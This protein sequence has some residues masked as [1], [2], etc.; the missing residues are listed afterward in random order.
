MKRHWRIGL[1]AI[2]IF[3]SGALVGASVSVAVMKR[4]AWHA[5]L[6]GPEAMRAQARELLVNEVTR[7]LDLTSAQRDDVRREID[8][9]QR[10]LAKV[11]LRVLPEIEAIVDRRFES[12]R[13]RL[14][15]LQ[16]PALRAFK[17]QLL[18]RLRRYREW[19]ERVTAEDS[20]SS[21]KTT[22]EGRPER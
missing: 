14:S 12:V 4:R 21:G 17:E 1:F 20:R 7:R 2:V 22:D 13:S 10:E 15:P 3:A 8:G 19:A 9:A 16:E 6:Q 11:R 5:Y 18:L